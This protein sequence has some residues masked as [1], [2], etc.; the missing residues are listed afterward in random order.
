MGVRQERAAAAAKELVRSLN[1]EAEKW[2]RIRIVKMY[3][4]WETRAQHLV[5]QLETLKQY[6]DKL[7]EEVQAFMAEKQAG[8]EASDVKQ[9]LRS[10]TSP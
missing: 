9:Q 7:E 2:H 1:D 8:G 4:E 3:E 6:L 10:P 5:Q